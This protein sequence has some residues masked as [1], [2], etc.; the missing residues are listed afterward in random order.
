MCDKMCE[1]GFIVQAGLE[2]VN[3]NLALFFLPLFLQIYSLDDA[4]P[5]YV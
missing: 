5:I 3:K 4:L 2:K 1:I